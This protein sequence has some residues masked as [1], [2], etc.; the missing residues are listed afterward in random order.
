MNFITFHDKTTYQLSAVMKTNATSLLDAAC[1]AA[2]RSVSLK[3]DV[4]VVPSVLARAVIAS[5]GWK[6]GSGGLHIYDATH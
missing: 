1:E 4:T 2:F 6:R 5:T 3:E